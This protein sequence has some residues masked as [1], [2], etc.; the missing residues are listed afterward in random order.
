MES[1]PQPGT[2][3]LSDEL[4]SDAQTVGDSAKER[5]RSEVD[6]RKGTAAD[7]AKKVSSALDSAADRLSDSPP[8]L[9][10]VFQQGADTLQRF[11][12]TIERKDARQLTGEVQ[13]FARD[14][15]GAFLGACALAG[16]AAARV[17]KA[18]ADDR[19]TAG[20]QGS[21]L[22]REHDPY[23]PQSSS[24]SSTVFGGMS[25]PQTGDPA[26]QGDLP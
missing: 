6:A 4:R 1:S 2:S 22:S 25:N 23:E 3:E 17:L 7:E 10:S 11:A 13:R 8:W 18:G 20:S 9:R 21:S 12:D 14:N 15:P 26:Y 5:L 24:G 16:F 19:A